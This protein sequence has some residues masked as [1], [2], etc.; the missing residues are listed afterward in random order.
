[1]RSNLVYKQTQI[2]PLYHQDNVYPSNEYE[3]LGYTWIRDYYCVE[4]KINTHRY[5]WNKR[6][7]NVM[8]SANFDLEFYDV[9]PYNNNKSRL[10]P[11]ETQ[12]KNLIA[13]FDEADQYSSFRPAL[14]EKKLNDS[15]ID[16]NAEYLKIGVAEDGIYRISK[17][18]LQSFNINT[19]AI[20]PN[21]FKI[22]LKGKQIPIYVFGEEDN[23]LDD[24][25]YIEFYGS[26]NYGEK[27]YRVLN[28]PDEPYNDYIDKYGD[29]T[30]YWLTWGGENGLRIDT[31]SFNPAGIFDTLNYYTNISHFEQNN[32]LDYSTS[33]I[34]D[35]QNPEWIYNESWIWGNH[36]V[37]TSN[38][39]FN[40][41]NLV[42]NKTAKAFFRLRSYASDVSVVKMLM[43]MP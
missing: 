41:D 22:F 9:K 20:D 15:W 17:S 37:G 11:F 42:S 28:Q 26:M 34:V 13:N 19:A 32:F 25:D 43:I 35:W 18:D 1:M 40:V 21:T 6:R 3:I 36:D 16:F 29:T 12:L 31:S 8:T 2:N 30:I 4:I 5:D 39:N 24:N 10:S 7:V 23:T 33:N 27:N 14:S 38:W